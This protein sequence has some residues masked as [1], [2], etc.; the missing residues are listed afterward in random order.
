MVIIERQI[1]KVRSG[2]WTELG[3]LDKK[4]TAIESQLGFP[5]KRRPQ[6][7]RRSHH[8]YAHY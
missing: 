5:A 4:F 3:E 7:G 8:R 2:K 6:P 1:Q